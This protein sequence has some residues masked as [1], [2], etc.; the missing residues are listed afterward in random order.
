[1]DFMTFPP[2][3][4]RLLMAALLT[5]PLPAA[6]EGLR[7]VTIP[8]D[9]IRHE[10]GHCFVADLDFGEEGDSDPANHSGLLLFEDGVPLG[11]AQS[12]HADIRSLGGGRYSHWTR[13]YLYFSTSDGSDPRTNERLYEVASTNPHSLL[14]GLPDLPTTPR[15]HA[16]N[17]DAARHEYV[18][19]MNG[20]LDMENTRI[21]STANCRVGFQPNLELEIANIGDTPVVNP[22]VVVN[23]RGDWRDRAS[24][25]RE[26]T[27]GASTDQEKALL[28]WQ[29]MRQHTYHHDPLFESDVQHDPVLLFNVFGFGLCDDAA[30]AGCALFREAGLHG[31]VCRALDGHVQCEAMV[32]GRLQFLDVDMD[33]FFL[34]RENERPV[35][36]DELA[37]D[38]DLVRRELNRGPVVGSFMPSEDLATLFGPDDVHFEPPRGDHRLDYI[39]RPGERVVFHWAHRGKFAAQD[40]AH[41][42]RPPFFGNSEFVYEPRLTLAALATDAVAADGW[43]E[44]PAP[45]E[46]TAVRSGA[47]VTYA[48]RVPWLICGGRLDLSLA[49]DLTATA[50]IVELSSDGV[51]WRRVWERRGPGD[52]QAGIPLDEALSLR[53]GAPAFDYQVRLTVAEPGPRL[54]ALRLTTDILVARLSLPR[55]RLGDNR[56]VYADDTKGPR[57]VTITHRWRETDAVTPLSPPASALSPAPGATVAADRVRYE[58][59]PVPGAR[60]YRLQVSLRPDFAWPYRSSLDVAIPVP[61]WEVPF[62][63]IYSP[64]VTYYW[65]V[66]C[67]GERGVLGPWSDTWS[68]TWDGP[69]VPVDLRADVQDDQVI[70]RWRPNPRGPRP[71]AYEIYGSNV[72]GFPI[73]REPYFEYGLGE[74]PANLLARETGTSLT[75]PVP[76]DGGDGSVAVYYRVVAIDAVGTRS[77]PS[78]YCE[79]PHPLVI[80][81]PVTTATIGRPYAYRMRSLASLGD[82][83]FRSRNGGECE[84]AFVDCELPRFSL[85][86]A[87]PW[88]TIDPESGLV[89]GTPPGPG[90]WRVESQV[91]DQFGKS[92][93]Q[94]WEVNVVPSGV[95]SG[96]G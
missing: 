8:P 23:D 95:S 64:G 35:S 94:V 80:S 24:L 96:G 67:L 3:L 51:N 68:F 63:G 25:A 14:P 36:G 12:P 30:Q 79:L 2:R 5:L 48:V 90:R 11:P 92:A 6:A 49:G 21:V 84:R 65:R 26:W 76:A 83:Q 43:E 74:L 50:C 60:R 87:P 37:R 72:R 47:Q 29:N 9:A 27:R 91:T 13:V 22:R 53:E 41:A 57:Q 28:L 59:E 82:L 17:A 52:V 38:H 81:R 1:M 55:L 46:L 71:V 66:R 39:L 93:R 34:D 75:V 88:L 40:E 15:E 10:D 61:R 54:T 16:E 86:E 70:L 7:R 69:R 85:R 20:T 62:D 19:T 4:C 18:I 77:G 32:D 89:T 44:G 45:G 31:S 73:A 78:D 33:C 58:W 42:L 56:V